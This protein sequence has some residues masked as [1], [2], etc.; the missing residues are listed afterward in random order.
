MAKSAVAVAFTGKVEDL[1]RSIGQVDGTLGKLVSSATGGYAVM[2]AAAVGAAAGL[3]KIG[4]SFDEQYDKIR[5]GTGKTGDA[6]KGLE[7]SFKQVLKDVPTDFNSAGTA[8]SDLNQKLGLTG[9]PLQVMS[10][11]F[12]ELSRITKTDLQGNLDAAT[13]AFRNFGEQAKFQAG[14]L[15]FLYRASQASGVS[16]AQLSGD[17]AS[18][19]TVLKSLGMDLQ[20]STA[21]FAALGKSGVDVSEVMPGLSKSLATAAKEGKDAGTLLQ[22]TFDKIKNAPDAATAAGD[23]MAVFGAKAGPKL[24][25][26]IREGKFS[27]DEMN[28]AIFDGSDTILKAGKETQDFGEKWTIIK[29]RV[30]VGL[31]P[32]ATAVFNGVG[33]AMDKVTAALD[34]LGPKIG[35]IANFVK[36]NKAPFEAL[37]AVIGGVL[38]VALIRWGVESTVAAAKAV[39]GFVASQ[40]K[41]V[42][43]VAVQLV[44]F[45]LLVAGYIAIGVQAAITGAAM[46]AAWLVGLG[47]IALVVAAVAG[48]ALLIVTHWDT[49]KNAAKAVWDWISTNWPLILAILTGPIGLAVLEISRHWDTIKNAFTAVKDWI[50]ARIGDI[51][52]FITGVPGRIAGVASSMFNAVKDAMTSVKNWVSDRIGDTVKFFKDLPHKIVSALGDVSKLLEK[53]GLSIMKSLLNGLTDGFKAVGHFVGGVAG[54]I[55]SLKGP[56]DYDAKLLIPHGSAI[57]QS[58]MDGLQAR[59]GPMLGMVSKIAEAVSAQFGV[60]LPGLSGGLSGDWSASAGGAGFAGAIANTGGQIVNHNYFDFSSLVATER[61]TLM[62]WVRGQLDQIARRNGI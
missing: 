23:A 30:L 24:A 17:L 7:G 60:Q 54:K 26:L 31:E 39:A 29:N 37:A 3:F 14:D 56:L 58:L 28:T 20:S 22:E 38:T 32:L 15:D 51:V 27:V 52:G 21:L 44:N 13:Q 45:A 53:A 10:E 40:I 42:E 46:A 19:G 43:S 8:I 18:N 4:E 47:P 50:G 11:K 48:A 9:A 41:A 12:L 36:D 59:Y 2:G 25:S 35:A 49:I 61:D 1:Q 6:L 33:T 62:N 16:F 55:A 5:V 34:V 57:M